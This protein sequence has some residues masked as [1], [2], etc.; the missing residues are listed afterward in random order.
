MKYGIFLLKNTYKEI[1]NIIYEYNKLL[2]VN[3]YLYIHT[4]F[5][6]ECYTQ[7]QTTLN[8]LNMSS[9]YK[10]DNQYNEYNY[11]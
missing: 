3:L 8:Y 9:N 11:L 1:S 4:I 6:Y 2:N 5:V 10:K 7:F